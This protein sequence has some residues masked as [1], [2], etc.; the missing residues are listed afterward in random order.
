MRIIITEGQYRFLK[1]IQ[2]ASNVKYEAIFVAGY[3]TGYGT[4]KQLQY[5]KSGCCCGQWGSC[6]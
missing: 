3:E 5:F 2:S 4:D 1:E 6:R